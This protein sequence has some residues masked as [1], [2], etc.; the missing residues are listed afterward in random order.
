MSRAAELHWE[1]LE[2]AEGGLLRATVRIGGARRTWVQVKV[3]LEG[4]VVDLQ[5]DDR[6]SGGTTGEHALDDAVRSYVV[7]HVALAR[8]AQVYAIASRQRNN[9]RRQQRQR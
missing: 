9:A 4:A 5:A 8:D 7:R 6:S 1:G 3:T 2:T